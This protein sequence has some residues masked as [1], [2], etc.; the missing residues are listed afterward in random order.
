MQLHL[1][2]ATWD[3]LNPQDSEPFSLALSLAVGTQSSSRPW[4]PPL[5]LVLSHPFP[6][7]LFPPLFPSFQVLILT[8]TF[9]AHISWICSTKRTKIKSIFQQLFGR[10]SAELDLKYQSFAHHFYNFS[11]VWIIS[12]FFFFKSINSLTSTLFQPH[13]KQTHQWNHRFGV[14]VVFF[15][16]LRH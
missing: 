16:L 12:I 11:Y 13:S 7:S 2:L 14:P 6:P 1:F 4:G 9:Q 15:F 8:V 5:A 3:P 10:G